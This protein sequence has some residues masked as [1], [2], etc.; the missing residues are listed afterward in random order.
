MVLSSAVGDDCERDAH[1]R[2]KVLRNSDCQSVGATKRRQ[3]T[4][5]AI[6]C[7]DVSNV[8]ARQAEWSHPDPPATRL[9]ADRHNSENYFDTP[10][11]ELARP[12]SDRGL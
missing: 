3:E 2:G 4:R 6:T 1:E 12:T 10:S 7:S 9:S 8:L 11:R 5:G